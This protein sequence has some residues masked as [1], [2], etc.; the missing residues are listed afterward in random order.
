MTSRQRQVRRLVDASPQLARSRRRRRV[1]STAAVRGGAGRVGACVRHGRRARAAA[2][3]AAAAAAV[4]AAAAAT[5]NRLERRLPRRPR[6]D[7]AAAATRLLRLERHDGQRSTSGAAERPAAEFRRR[8]VRVRRDDRSVSGLVAA[9]DVEVAPASGA[10]DAC[11]VLG[12][13][14]DWDGPQFQRL[15]D[16]VLVVESRRSRLHHLGVDARRHR[17]STS[18]AALT[19]SQTRI[20]S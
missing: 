17:T 19:P 20:L 1:A 12:A 7:A 10:E 13:V 5:R 6:A 4:G 18:T 2:C 9:Q 3:A 16:A 15:V 14:D 11:D 8:A